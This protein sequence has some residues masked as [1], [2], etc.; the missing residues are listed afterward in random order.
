MLEGT[1][2]CKFLAKPDWMKYRMKVV[3]IPAA[4]KTNLYIIPTS[5]G[6]GDITV[7]GKTLLTNVY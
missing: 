1:L 6:D 7:N 5:T 3:S 2:K 4:G